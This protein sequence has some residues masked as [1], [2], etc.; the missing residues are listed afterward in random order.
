MF[1]P[2]LAHEFADEDVRRFVLSATCR[3]SLNK[4][5]IRHPS[6]SNGF[7]Y[8]PKPAHLPPLNA[9]ATGV[10]PHL[11]HAHPPLHAL[12]ARLELLDKLSTFRYRRMKL[13]SAF[14][15]MSR[16]TQTSLSI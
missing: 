9:I 11:F 2:L 15:A 6:R 13:L 1:L 14:L 5:K 8:P 7:A 16:M 4:G 12:V 3:G 10:L